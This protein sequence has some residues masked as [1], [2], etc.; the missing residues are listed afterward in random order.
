MPTQTAISVP[1]LLVA[2][3]MNTSSDRSF[4]PGNHCLYFSVYLFTFLM[5]LPLHLVALVIFVGKLQR[6]P[7]AVHVLSLNLTL[8]DPILLP[9]LPFR[10]VQAESGTCW[11]LP[12]IFCP[13]SRFLF[14]TTIYLTSLFLAAVSDERFLSVAYPVWY[15]TRSRPGQARLVSGA[16]W[17]LAAAHCTVV[18]ATEFSG[19]SSPTQ[20]IN[21]TC[22]LEFWKDQLVGHATWNSGRLS[23]P[24]SCL[25][26]WRW[27]RSFLGCPCS[28]PATAVAAWCAY[29]VREPASAGGRGWRARSGH[30]AQL[31]RLLWALQCVPCCGLHP[32]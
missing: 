6:C 20:G 7:V 26:S 18:H 8:S 19:C 1:L 29:S 3:T 15:K 9:F 10:V 24:F 25:S 27:L 4:F 21:G 17:L 12:F 5:G 28:S 31:P 16:C 11:S 2:M 23:R 30:A 32:G 13:F 14:F 22:Y